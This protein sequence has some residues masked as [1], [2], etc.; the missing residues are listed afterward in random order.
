VPTPNANRMDNELTSIV[1]VPGTRRLWAFG[2]HYTRRGELH[3]LILHRDATGWTVSR[4]LRHTPGARL[5]AGTFVPGRHGGVWAVGESMERPLIERHTP[6]GWE[7]VPSP[8][9]ARPS[10]LVGAA[11]IPGTSHLWAVGKGRK[12][13][14]ER[15]SG[16][17]WRIIPSPQPAGCNQLSDVIALSPLNAWV[18][19]TGT[20]CGNS[21]SPIIEHYS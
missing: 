17:V 6:A 19:G 9:L 18:V 21:T 13:V 11:A 2:F 5:E 16:R 20:S 10:L 15:W 1:A 14:I 7:R 4:G 8:T 12:L 3:Q